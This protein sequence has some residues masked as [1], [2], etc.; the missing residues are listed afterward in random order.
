MLKDTNVSSK[1]ILLTSN[2]GMAVNICQ[3][4]CLLVA[5]IRMPEK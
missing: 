1:K 4:E 2:W 3:N 5:G